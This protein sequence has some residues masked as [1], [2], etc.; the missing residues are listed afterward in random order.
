MQGP[1]PGA[2]AGPRGACPG[3]P[4][5]HPARTSTRAR[6]ARPRQ[7]RSLRTR[8]AS[9]LGSPA[10]RPPPGTPDQ[11][12]VRGWLTQNLGEQE[13]EQDCGLHGNTTSGAQARLLLSFP[14]FAFTFPNR[15]SLETPFSARRGEGAA[16]QVLFETKTRGGEPGCPTHTPALLRRPQASPLQ[17]SPLGCVCPPPPSPLLPHTPKHTQKRRAR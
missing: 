13:Q 9:E 5:L 15:A 11:G 2:V 8:G 17:G 12:D 14:P 3:G 6:R 4:R 10:P 16:R 7:A 1:R